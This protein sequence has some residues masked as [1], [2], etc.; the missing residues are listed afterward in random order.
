MTLKL[1]FLPDELWYPGI[2]NDGYRF[3]L[4]AESEYSFD[5]D[6]NDTFNQINPILLSSRGRYVWAERCKF[7]VRGGELYVDGDKI[8]S[9]TAGDTLA[10][11][12]RAARKFY[13][14]SGSRPDPVHFTSPQYCTWIALGENHSQDGVLDF[15][16]TLLDKGFE[17]GLIIID[18]SWQRDYG[19]WRFNDRFADPKAMIAELK[20]LG[21]KVSLWLVPYVSK[22]APDYEKLRSLGA[23]ITDENGEIAQ[24]KWWKDVN[25][26]LDLTKKAAVEW[27]SG[28]LD[29][30]KRDYGVDGFKLDGGD[31]AFY[32][33]CCDG[34]GQSEA[35]A[36]FY[37]S[38]IKE[39]RA[40]HKAAGLAITQR[41]ADKAHEWKVVER[42]DGEGNPYLSYGLEAVLPNLLVQGLVGYSFG[43]PDM[44]GGGLACDMDS[45]DKID[46]ELMIR[47][48]EAEILAPSLQFSYPVWKMD[49]KT[50]S[51]TLELLELRK[52]FLPYIAALY[53]AAA[54]TGEPITRLLEYQYPHEGLGGETDCFALGDR[55]VVYPILEKGASGRLVA[56]PR[57]KWLRDGETVSGGKKIYVKS[58]RL[59]VFEKI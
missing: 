54:A 46:P 50:V 58:D 52:R 49:E 20:N 8:E 43:C 26:A 30:L 4:S 59:I 48:L 14:P 31:A 5:F 40:C 1:K 2:V 42:R 47:S 12:A 18:D 44:V 17:P 10:S 53:E 24:A 22:N 11:A 39:L 27:L 13:P 33:P 6:T 19:D 15:A 38:E 56:L 37:P 29:G 23:L 7:F 36:T 41:L 28:V 25:P 51:R 32:P 16:R 34:Q 45:G 9:G 55:Y 35:W 21:F 57:G 3:P